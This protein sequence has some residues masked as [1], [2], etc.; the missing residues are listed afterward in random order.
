MHGHKVGIGTGL[1][2]SSREGL[3]VKI[4]CNHV[5]RTLFVAC[6]KLQQILHFGK[7]SWPPLR[8]MRMTTS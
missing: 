3:G 1:C 6:Q 5:S 8:G 4:A 7:H 2:R